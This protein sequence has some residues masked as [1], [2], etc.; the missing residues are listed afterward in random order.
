MKRRHFLL[1]AGTGLAASLTPA[2]ADIA[3]DLY[4]TA[5]NRPDNSTWLTGLTATGTV[6]FALPLPSRGHAAA[7]HPERAEAVAFARRPGDFALVLDVASGRELA[8]LTTPEGLHFYGHGAFTGDGR[9]LLTTENAYDVPDGRI[10]VWDVAAGYARAGDFPSG[11]LG[12]HEMIRLSDGTFAVANGGIQT[13]PDFDRAKL[14]LPTMQTNL[15]ILTEGGS[16]VSQ[17]PL[18]GAMR[19]NSVRHIAA[20]AAGRIVAGLQWQGDPTEP[21]PLVAR[22]GT[23]AAP[24]LIDHPATTRLKQ[25]AG[26]IAVSPDGS[27]IAVTGPKGDHVL[28]LS[29]D[30]AP[31]DDAGLGAASG[32][33]QTAGGLLITCTGGIAHRQ[34]GEIE[35]IP[36]AGDWTWDNHLVRVG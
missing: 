23:A 32:V 10:G 14:N 29:G 17:A 11:G 6:A 1:G 9:Y 3:P 28:F 22:F 33:A 2:W 7:A 5:A 31:R 21:V 27:E 34:D 12:P 13:H 19:Q 18:E 24:E 36:V 15:S 26:S 4:L 30:G 20:D 16:L 8:R 35:P 25:Y